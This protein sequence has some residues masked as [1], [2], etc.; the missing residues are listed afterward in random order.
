M[1]RSLRTLPRLAG[2]LRMCANQAL[3]SAAS[4]SQTCLMPRSFSK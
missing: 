1:V 2:V 4:T 3:M